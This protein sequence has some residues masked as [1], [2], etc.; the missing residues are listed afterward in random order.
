M[1]DD[2][3]QVMARLRDPET[4]CPWDRKQSFETIAPY[5]IEEAYEVADAIARGDYE[6]LRDELG[7]LLLQVAYHAQIA[8]ERGLFDFEDVSRAIVAKLVRRH[9]H[10]FGEL[11]A[12]DDAELARRWEADKARTRKQRGRH[13]AFDGLARNLPALRMAH[14]LQARAAQDGFDWKEGVEV[15]AKLDEELDEVRQAVAV[16]DGL[17]EEIGDLLFTVVNLSRRFSID[18]ETALRKA[19]RKFETRFN[20]VEDKLKTQG[21]GLRDATL[22]E[23]DALW[24]EVK[25]EEA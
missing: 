16:G 22:Q 8:S 4:G 5:T 24:E 20:R 13:G 1:L 2:L 6:D 10:V 9:P 12:G 25:A 19:N 21:R 7:D 15:L 23:L 14:K 3:L 17:V 11:Q 18:A